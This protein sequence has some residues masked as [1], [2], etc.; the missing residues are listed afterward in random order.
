MRKK[1]KSIDEKEKKIMKK[2][3]ERKGKINPEKVK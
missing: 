1:R 3:K 2:M